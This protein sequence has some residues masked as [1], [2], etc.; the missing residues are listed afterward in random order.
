[1][2]VLR[3]GMP[4]KLARISRLMGRGGRRVGIEVGCGRQE[5]LDG[6]AQ[7]ALQ[8]VHYFGIGFWMGSAPSGQGGA[9]RKF[10]FPNATSLPDH[11]NCQVGHFLRLVAWPSWSKA[12]DLRLS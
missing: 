1:M 6:Q 5:T 7:Q 10:S 11:H 8:A 3:N 9:Y 4:V 12:L 2:P